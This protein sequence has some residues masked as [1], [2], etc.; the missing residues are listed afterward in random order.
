[1]IINEG[2]CGMP[3]YPVAFVSMRMSNNTDSVGAALGE[4]QKMS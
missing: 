3:Q 4:K 1:M 2:Y